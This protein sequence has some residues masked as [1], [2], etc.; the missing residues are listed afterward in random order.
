MSRKRSPRPSR[1]RANRA[2]RVAGRH[3]RKHRQQTMSRRRTNHRVAEPSAGRSASASA[4]RQSFAVRSSRRA[5]P[6]YWSAHGSVS[7]AAAETGARTAREARAESSATFST[8]N[9]GRAHIADFG[10]SAR[11]WPSRPKRGGSKEPRPKKVYR[12]PTPCA[13][14]T[15]LIPLASRAEVFALPEK[16][17][18]QPPPPHL[19][20]R[21]RKI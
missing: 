19:G 2:E 12:T 21:P 6:L 9:R 7:R 11:L 20:S 17:L 16:T 15:P 10:A 14:G 4:V 1:H 13:N 3:R 5:S 18:P 8:P